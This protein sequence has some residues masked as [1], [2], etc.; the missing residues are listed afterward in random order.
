MNWKFVSFGA[1]GLILAVIGMI[2]DAA[3][4]NYKAIAV[5]KALESVS[6]ETQNKIQDAENTIKLA[7]SVEDR[8]RKELFDL[9]KTWKRKNN[10]DVRVK[11]AHNKTI[12]AMDEFKQSIG[13]FDRKQQIEDEYEAAVDVFKDSIDYDYEL[14]LQ[15]ASI[16]DAKDTYKKRCKRI[17]SASGSDD[18]ISDALKDLRKSEKEKMDEAIKEAKSAISS[19]KSKLSTEENKLLRTKQQ[20]LRELESELQATKSKLEKIESDTLGE[21]YHEESKYRE[22]ARAMIESK[23]TA[24][25]KDALDRSFECSS[26]LKNNDNANADMAEHLFDTASKSEKWGKYLKSVNCPKWLV[27]FVGALPL[28]PVG[29][30]VA[31]YIQFIFDVI[32]AM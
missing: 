16:E 29:F 1:A 28:I 15:E 9:M 32:G 20:R 6:D 11:E 17:D 7:D 2:N 8:E 26:Y 4:R 25:E 31:R 27:G 13:Y 10:Y 19:L 23:R 22:E 5:E 12:S 21:L 30:G 24:D 18:D 3:N 14:A